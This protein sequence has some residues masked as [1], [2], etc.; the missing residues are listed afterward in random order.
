MQAATAKNT[1]IKA[2]QLLDLPLLGSKS[3]SPPAFFPKDT[4]GHGKSHYSSVD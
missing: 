3:Y 2:S 4:S 1:T